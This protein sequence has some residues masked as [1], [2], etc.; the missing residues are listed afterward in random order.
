MFCSSP[1]PPFIEL[2]NPATNALRFLP[3]ARNAS[4]SLARSARCFAIPGSPID[5]MSRGWECRIGVSDRRNNKLD[6]RPGG[7]S[8][9]DG[10]G[11]TMGPDCRI[12]RLWIRNRTWTRRY[13]WEPPWYSAGLRHAMNLGEMLRLSGRSPERHLATLI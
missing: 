6:Q 4:R 13:R 10:M 3:A 8:L 9:G 7:S 1:G 5:E 2:F 11:R 12:S